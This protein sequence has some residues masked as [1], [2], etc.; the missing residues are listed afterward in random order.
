MISQQSIKW[1]VVWVN[2][3]AEGKKKSACVTEVEKNKLPRA[4]ILHGFNSHLHQKE[5][6][7]LILAL[8][9]LQ[10]LFRWPHKLA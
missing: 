4:G 2:N 10:R 6:V 8:G 5:D 9:K 1:T 7:L 3:K